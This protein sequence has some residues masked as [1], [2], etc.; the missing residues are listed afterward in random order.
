MIE[1]LSI[2]SN[3][4]EDQDRFEIEFS[5]Q[6]VNNTS[7]LTPPGCWVLCHGLSEEE[8][9]NASCFQSSEIIRWY[10]TK[11]LNLSDGNNANFLQNVQHLSQMKGDSVKLSN[12]TMRGNAQ[13]Y[14]RLQFTAEAS[15]RVF[16]ICIFSEKEQEKLTYVYSMPHSEIDKTIE[17]KK[18][19]GG[20][21]GLFKKLKTI[22]T[23]GEESENVV[24]KI[25]SRDNRRKVLIY[26]ANGVT[27]YS[28]IPNRCEELYLPETID[29]RSIKIAYLVSLINSKM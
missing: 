17:R 16:L 2:S 6:W 19:Q 13:Q 24:L 20:V 27:T 14:H 4:F 8:V 9:L 18:P 26:T 7:D 22:V 25:N 23:G 10:S 5:W 1:N 29:E 15:A 28:I 11:Y 21:G 3:L 12:C